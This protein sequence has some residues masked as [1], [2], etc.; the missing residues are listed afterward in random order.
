MPPKVFQIVCASA[1]WDFSCNHTRFQIYDIIHCLHAWVYVVST[2]IY[3]LLWY[4]AFLFLFLILT[5]IFLY[6]LNNRLS[7]TKYML[8]NRTY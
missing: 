4:H 5:L 2:Q 6:Y 1:S 3:S 8:Q 7:L